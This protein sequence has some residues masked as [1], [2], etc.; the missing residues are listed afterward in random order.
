[1]EYVF[2]KTKRKADYVTVFALIL[3]VLV[4][5]FE[6]LLVSWLPNKL[7]ET[8]V[9]EAETA[10]QEVIDLEDSLRHKIKSYEDRVTTGE[11]E[12]VGDCLD[13]IARYLRLNNANMTRDQVRDVMDDLFLF[14]KIMRKWSKGKSYS[15]EYQIDFK[16]QLSQCFTVENN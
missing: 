3:F 16:S 7:K 6:L 5:S 1:M 14:E 11:V 9:L 12:L 13:D 4:M 10:K 2:N 15:S 8:K